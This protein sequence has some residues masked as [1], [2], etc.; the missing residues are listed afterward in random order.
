MPMTGIV[1]VERLGYTNNGNPRYS[2]LFKPDDSAQVIAGFTKPNG[3]GFHNMPREGRAVVEYHTTP[4][5][6]T[7]FTSIQHP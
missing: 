3:D 6:R 5:G 4:S 7:I 2:V 1:N